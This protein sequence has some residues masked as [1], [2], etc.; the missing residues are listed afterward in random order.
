MLM[1]TDPFRELDRFANAVLGT[2]ARP[3]VMPMDS[4]SYID[5]TAWWISDAHPRPP[6]MDGAPTNLV[7]R[8]SQLNARR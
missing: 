4:A 8:C 2:A 1:R 3:A 7:S 6:V 5:A